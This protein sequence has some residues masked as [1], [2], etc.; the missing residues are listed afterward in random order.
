MSFKSDITD[1]T[2]AAFPALWIVTHEEERAEKELQEV[3][4]AEKAGFWRWSVT[5][6]W[7]SDDGKVQKSQDPK[8]AIEQ[9][10]NMPS[11]ALYIFRDFHPY[12]KNPATNRML[13]DI[14]P[15]CKSQAKTLIILS[16]V[17]DIPTELEKEMTV[18]NFAL[19]TRE[20]LGDKLDAVVAEVGKTYARGKPEVEDRAAILDAASGLTSSEAENAFSLAWSRTRDDKVRK[21]NGRAVATVRNEKA[22]AIKKSNLV[23]WVEPKVSIDDVGGLGNLK[24]DLKVIAP[25]FHNPDKAKA[26]GFRDE[27]FPRSIA[28][29][30][31][32]GTGKSLTAEAIP[33]LLQVGAVRTDFGRI[34]SAGGGKVG[35]AEN[36]I[37]QRNKLVEAMAPVVDW[38]DEAEKGLAGASGASTQN[39][40][41]ARIGATILTWFEQFRAR[42]MVVA[43]IN[44]VDQLPPE[45]MNR[46]QRTY[47]VD[48]PDEDELVEIF[49]IH[50][51]A[52][53]IKLDAEKIRRLAIKTHGYNGREIRNIV[54]AAMQAAFSASEKS[55]SFERLAEAI[56]AITPL[57][58]SRASDVEAIRKWAKDH[59]IRPAGKSSS[60]E[61]AT[62]RRIK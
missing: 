23:E 37:E 51:A 41:E 42:V 48:L 2:Q 57:S 43:T 6:G 60:A 4:K 10:I 13:R 22:G 33:Q 14:I 29:I 28:L 62:G 38:W 53:N 49:T 20:E 19:P 58:V 55:V 56:E 47:F 27:D 1:Y 44:R 8:Q 59:K 17:L 11:E 30:G 12:L 26:F 46:F 34:F 9:V 45:M 18:V 61:T 5:Q 36:N 52:R 16:P 24:A 40:W 7:A 50:L 3:A 15:L 25:I 39:P 54:Q 21:F 32:P 35:A 31:V